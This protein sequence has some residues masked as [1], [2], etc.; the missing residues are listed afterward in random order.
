MSRSST[1]TAACSS[2]CGVATASA[3][4]AISSRDSAR[5]SPAALSA[6]LH[7]RPP[8][9]DRRGLPEALRLRARGRDGPRRRFQLLARRGDRRGSSSEARSAERG[10]RPPARAASHSARGLEAARDAQQEGARPRRGPFRRVRVLPHGA[11]R[12][13][14]PE[15][16]GQVYLSLAPEAPRTSRTPPNT[17]SPPSSSPESRPRGQLTLILQVVEQ[18]SVGPLLTPSSHAS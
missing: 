9:R 13:P 1:S 3:R 4:S 16:D 2:R 5:A 10:R 8:G 14:G 11:A 15:I 18:L 7:R 12:R 17:I 6:P